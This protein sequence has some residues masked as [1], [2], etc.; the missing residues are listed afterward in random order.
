MF[1]KLL[2]YVQTTINKI[3]NT[4]SL[5]ERAETLVY[6]ALPATI[7]PDM[8]AY[9]YLQQPYEMNAV[10]SDDHMWTFDYPDSTLYGLAP[11]HNMDAVPKKLQR[12]LFTRNQI[13]LIN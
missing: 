4:F 11:N 8:W 6:N 7:T 12:T 1:G 9:Q 3:K 2:L 13:L 5:A 10:H